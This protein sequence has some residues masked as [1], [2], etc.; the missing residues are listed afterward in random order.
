ME[1]I[2]WQSLD[3]TCVKE[4][5]PPLDREADQ[6]YRTARNLQKKDEEKYY[7]EIFDFYIKAAERNHYKA[8]I[9]LST[10]YVDG[11]VVKADERIAVEYVEKVI[12]LNV[13]AGYYQ[14]GVFLEQGIGVKQ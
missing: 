4:V 10:L 14:M 2:D 9:W 5:N 13:P 6:W 3:F 11:I 1:N 7:K 12:R 8:L